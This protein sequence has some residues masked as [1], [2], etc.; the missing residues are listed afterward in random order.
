MH[1]RLQQTTA[2]S[3]LPKGGWLRQ[4][5]S[6]GKYIFNEIIILPVAGDARSDSRRSKAKTPR[7]ISTNW[8]AAILAPGSVH[9]L[10]FTFLAQG[11][12]V[13][14]ATPHP[15]PDSL[16]HRPRRSA[17]ELPNFPPVSTSGIPFVVRGCVDNARK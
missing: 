13:L 4:L 12:R 10:D 2:T 6:G 5:L 15:D 16:S 1:K 14:S 17:S 3:A 9:G 11:S 7:A 8:T